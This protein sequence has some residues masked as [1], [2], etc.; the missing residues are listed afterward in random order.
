[1]GQADE[2]DVSLL[3]LTDPTK[4]ESAVATLQKNEAVFG[5][6]E[7]FWGQ[8]LALMFGNPHVDPRVPDIAIAPNVGVVYTG[9]KAKVSEHGGF[10]NDDR[11]V[12]LIVSN[13]RI[14]PATATGQ[15]ETRQIAP[16]ILQVLGLDPNAL[17]AVRK[18]GTVALPGLIY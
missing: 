1:M 6:G 9:G 10:S 13:S 8:S 16:T 2:D 3:W 5:G 11:N 7:I 18:E 15:V 17:Q 12:L 4:V 14:S